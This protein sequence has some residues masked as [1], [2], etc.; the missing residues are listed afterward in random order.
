MA[1]LADALADLDDELED[2][3]GGGP[4]VEDQDEDGGDY[5]DGREGMTEEEIKDLEESV[6]PVRR[7][8]TKV[9]HCHTPV[10]LFSHCS[11]HLWSFFLSP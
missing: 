6:K 2:D 5:P 8:L 11:I 7:V 1:D 9:R 4:G 10:T 3:G